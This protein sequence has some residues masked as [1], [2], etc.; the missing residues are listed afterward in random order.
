MLFRHTVRW[1]YPLG[2]FRSPLIRN[3]YI[4]RRAIA[5][6]PTPEGEYQRNPHDHPDLMKYEVVDDETSHPAGPLK[7][8][9][10]KDV[11]G[12][13][14][15]FDIV[16]VDREIARNDLLLTKSA[17]YASPFDLIYY[18]KM[19]ERMRD[20]LASRIRIPYD[21]LVVGRRLVRQIIPLHVSM[22]KPWTIDRTIIKVSLR[23]SGIDIVDDAIYIGKDAPSGPNFDIEAKL[24][25]FYVVICKQ[26]IVPMLG[27]ISHIS[28]DE[29]RQVLYPETSV[30][31]DI[32]E[33]E[34]YGLRTEEPYFHKSADV[35]KDFEVV[36]F[37]KNRQ[38]SQNK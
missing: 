33:L 13:G 8:I 6:E 29:T 26:Y 12:I 3:T 38:N 24:I 37:M 19:K 11:E 20:E 9:L 32:S 22:D 10:L 1:L 27:R 4:L 35:T 28:T 25:R 21:Y 36:E 34:K 30:F 16:D 7:V 31:P 23:E 2:L 17:T 18:G 5:P 15:Q 14:H